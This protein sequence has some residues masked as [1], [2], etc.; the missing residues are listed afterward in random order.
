[1]LGPLRVELDTVPF[2]IGSRKGLALLVYDR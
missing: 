2:E 1:M